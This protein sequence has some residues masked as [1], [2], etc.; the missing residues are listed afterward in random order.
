MS[1][2]ICPER[3]TQNR[4]IN[5]FTNEKNSN[6]LGYEYL[7]DWSKKE[8]NKCIETELLKII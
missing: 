3:K 5:L 8:N 1:N 2:K 7:G 4:V 6:Y